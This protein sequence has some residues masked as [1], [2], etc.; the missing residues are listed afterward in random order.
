M[1][2]NA[3][4]LSIIITIIG[5]IISIIGLVVVSQTKLIAKLY[6]E[7][8]DIIHLDFST[9]IK[10]LEEEFK[11]EKRVNMD[12]RHSYAASASGMIEAIKHINE[13]F[14]IKLDH[15]GEKIDHLTKQIE[16]LNNHGR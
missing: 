6:Q 1:E 2:S 3:Q 8:Q 15:I 10:K 12:F 13:T 4:T 5:S 11:E 14:D 16:D 7:K 9:K